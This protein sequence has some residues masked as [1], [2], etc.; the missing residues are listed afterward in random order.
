MRKI[1]IK[2]EGVQNDKPTLQR[3]VRDELLM[4]YNSCNWSILSDSPF[5]QDLIEVF[6]MYGD[7]EKWI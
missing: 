6:E 5:L 3:H 1:Q 4:S 2:S 7:S